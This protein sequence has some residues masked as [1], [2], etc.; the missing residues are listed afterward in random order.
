MN[1]TIL[2]AAILIVLLTQSLLIIGVIVGL[3]MLLKRE[4]VSN[5]QA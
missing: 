4:K 1:E 2:F 5:G 3:F